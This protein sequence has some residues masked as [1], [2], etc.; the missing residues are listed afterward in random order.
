MI[1]EGSTC[2]VSK[3]LDND[4]KKCWQNLLKA[5]FQC[6]MLSAQKPLLAGFWSLEEWK[7]N[8]KQL[9][10]R[11]FWTKMWR[12]ADKTFSKRAFSA[13]CLRYSNRVWPE[14]EAWKNDIGRINIYC[15][16]KF[17]QW[18]EEMLTKPSQSLVSVLYAFGTETTFGRN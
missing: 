1:L 6:S 2:I 8:G 12:N 16:Q 15:F 3:I 4:V 13:L 9:L 18:C 11:K 5:W 10:L 7:W 17:G 14:L